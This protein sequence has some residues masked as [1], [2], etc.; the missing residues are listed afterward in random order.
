MFG[1]SSK[2][3]GVH[4]LRYVSKVLLDLEQG[5]DY[6]IVRQDVKSFLAKSMAKGTPLPAPPGPATSP[7][8][9]WLLAADWVR[10]YHHKCQ[11]GTAKP[12]CDNLRSPLLGLSLTSELL[13]Y[14]TVLW[15][16]SCRAREAGSR[17]PILGPALQRGT[18]TNLSGSPSGGSGANYT[19]SGVQGRGPFSPGGRGAGGGQRWGQCGVR[20]PAAV[21]PREP[22]ASRPRSRQCGRGGAWT[23]GRGVRTWGAWQGRGRATALGHGLSKVD[24]IFLDEDG[25]KGPLADCDAEL[26]RKRRELGVLEEER[27]RREY[28]LEEL[29][30]VADSR[31]ADAKRL[32]AEAEEARKGGGRCCS[33]SSR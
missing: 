26:E 20:V 14:C 7:A 1:G 28:Q 4:L 15:C 23:Q 30:N 29:Q 31:E 22:L 11:L 27:K 13:L 32:E 9:C 5:A 6:R 16:T 10:V 18:P 25:A 2:P 24:V 19:P 17:S 12:D 3:R 33:T 8:G 21:G